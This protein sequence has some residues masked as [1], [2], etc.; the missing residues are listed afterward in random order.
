MEA[1]RRQISEATIL[2]ENYRFT[3]VIGMVVL[4]FWILLPQKNGAHWQVRN[5]NT[6]ML[7]CAS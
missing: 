2:H 3:A 6:L 7:D 4:V 1:M 5:T